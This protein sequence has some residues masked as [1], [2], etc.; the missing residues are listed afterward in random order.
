M[1][2]HDFSEF[3]R[4]L[5]PSRRQQVVDELPSMISSPI[6]DSASLLEDAKSVR[7][8]G[9]P[10]C[11]SG[12]IRGNGKHKGVRRHHCKGCGKYF[13]DSTGKLVFALKKPELFPDCPYHML[14]G[15]SIEKCA[16]HTGICVQ[17]SFDRRH[18]VSGAFEEA[19]PEGFRGIAESDDI[20]FLESAKG[21]KNP[22]RKPRK[23]GGKAGRRGIGDE[24][25]AVVATHDRSGNTEL[26]VATKGRVSKKDLQ[27]VFGEKLVGRICL[28]Q[29]CFRIELTKNSSTC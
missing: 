2:P 3:F 11:G 5:A 4:G 25:V 21:R 26:R 24:Q 1:I 18:K 7:P 28:I 22:G 17:T 27:K 6:G 10:H 19:C 15:L 8:T 14:M 29:P 16:R 9:C 12:E 20:F 13:R 23:R